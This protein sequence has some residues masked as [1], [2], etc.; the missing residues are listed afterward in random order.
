[1]NLTKIPTL[2]LRRQILLLC[3]GFFFVGIIGYWLFQHL[4]ILHSYAN[5]GVSDITIVCLLVL[6][7]LLPYSLAHRCKLSL[8]WY[9]LA[10]CPSIFILA[11]IANEH[12]GIG[13]IIMT[14]MMFIIWLIMVIK[15]PRLH[16]HPLNINLC[17]LLLVMT[18]ALCCSNTDELTHNRHKVQHLID[19]GQYE[20]ALLVGRRSHATDA[21]L[22]NL[23]ATALLHTHQLGNRLFSYPV[24]IP[25]NGAAP[26]ISIPSGMADSTD[27]RDILLCNLLLKKELPTFSKML[28]KLYDNINSTTLPLHYKEALVIYMSRSTN[29]G[30]SYSNTLVEANYADFIAEKKK[31]EAAAESKSKC[32]DLYGNSYFWYYFFHQI[33]R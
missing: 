26:R 24:P 25:G 11:I 22:F 29:P 21:E 7:A 6:L 32:H 1:M 18:A 2:S 9:A 14:A 16:C 28:P 13:T 3:W 23:R 10:F 30:L 31:Y 27:T 19:K 8:E 20:D 15:Q 33:N 5:M 12:I 4:L 17:T